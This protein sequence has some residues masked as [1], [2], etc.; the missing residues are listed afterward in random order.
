MIKYN[1]SHTPWF[2]HRRYRTVAQTI[3]WFIVKRIDARRLDQIGKS[4]SWGRVCRN[5]VRIGLSLIVIG[6]VL[7]TALVYIGVE[8]P[9]LYSALGVAAVFGMALTVTGLVGV[10]DTS[11]T[12]KQHGPDALEME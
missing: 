12:V 2:V 7:V 1:Y 10:H 4:Q 6:V 9:E 3:R 11:Q 5:F 8:N